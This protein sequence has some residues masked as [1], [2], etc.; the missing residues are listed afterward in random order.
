VEVECLH[1]RTLS[2]WPEKWSRRMFPT[3]IM[4]SMVIRLAAVAADAANEA[5]A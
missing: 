1:E 3:D 5:P 4:A 2:S